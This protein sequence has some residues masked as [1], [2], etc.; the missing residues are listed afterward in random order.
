MI[1]TRTMTQLSIADELAAK[2]YKELGYDPK[3]KT[4]SPSPNPSYPSPISSYHLIQPKAPFR[5]RGLEKTAYQSATG[6]TYR[7]SALYRNAI[8]FQL[9]IEKWLSGLETRKHHRLITQ[10]TDAVRSMV[11]N[12]AEGYARPTTVEYLQFLV[13]VKRASRKSLLT[14]ST[15]KTRSSCHPGRALTSPPSGSS[16]SHHLLLISPMPLLHPPMIL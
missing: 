5:I 6:T 14:W 1:V 2:T 3:T 11:A 8:V 4:Y 15:P 7:Y 9:L 13:L 12:I 16:L 10:D